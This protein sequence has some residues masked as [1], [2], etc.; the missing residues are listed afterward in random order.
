MWYTANKKGDTV[1][2]GPLPKR[3]MARILAIFANRMCKEESIVEKQAKKA[4]DKGNCDET[5]KLV[6]KFDR[7][8]SM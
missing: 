7:F 8:K 5:S 6:V 4:K 2:M 1:G 3:S